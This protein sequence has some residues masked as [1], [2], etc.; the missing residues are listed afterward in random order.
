ML[1]SCAVNT[2]GEGAW[3]NGQGGSGRDAA[4]ESGGSGAGAAHGGGG[5][6]GGTS[7]IGGT[8]A[9]GGAGGSGATAGAGGTGGSGG[10]GAG[11]DAGA[12]AGAGGQAGAAIESSC[13]NGVDDD[14]N[15]LKDCE[16]PACQN[17]YEC[18]AAPP[19]GW[20]QH[21]FVSGGAFDPG[22]PKP[23][24]PD[25][26]TSIRFF[27]GPNEAPTCSPCACASAQGG[28][29][30][31]ALSCE[32]D[33]GSCDG[34]AP[35][36][37]PPVSPGCH[38]YGPVLNVTIS[39]KMAPPILDAPG[40]CMASGGAVT[41]T[42]FKGQ[43]QVCAIA[44]T[45]YCPQGRVCVPKRAG[46]WQLS[47]LCVA[48][49]TAG[50]TCPSTGWTSQ[51]V[52][53]GSYTDSR[54]CV[55]CQCSAPAG[56][57]CAQAPYTIWACSQN[58]QPGASHCAGYAGVTLDTCQ[59]LSTVIGPVDWSIMVTAPQLTP[60]ACTHSGGEPKAGGLA[61]GDGVTFCCVP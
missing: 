58:C 40:S 22:A 31:P 43:D 55:G 14:A 48:K 2:Q 59:D 44:Q 17:D 23:A 34:T 51:I 5:G 33:H 21:A 25:G 10:S 12:D 36:P 41:N 35:S 20:K 50:E 47:R 1:G 11:K 16:D 6:I 56:A 13:L 46:T 39:C 27:E 4:V 8:G 18:V 9:A 57:G 32:N 54:G 49:G 19:T 38:A 42:P 37:V 29:C 61:K 3:G 52:A 30:T 53:Y 45:G 7:G 24:C 15:G 26:S 60:G 28:H